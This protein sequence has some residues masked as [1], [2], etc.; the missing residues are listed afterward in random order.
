MA[1]EITRENITKD[2]CHMLNIEFHV[3]NEIMEDKWNLPLTSFFF[4]LNAVQLYQLLMAV[5]EKYNIYFNASEIEENGFG[6]LEEIIRL[7]QLKLE[8]ILC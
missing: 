5:G 1:E 2:I 3:R 7:I 8:N 4:G 6:T